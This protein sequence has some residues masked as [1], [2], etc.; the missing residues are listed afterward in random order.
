MFK[1]IRE[2]NDKF[3]AER[4]WGYSLK[5]MQPENYNLENHAHVFNIPIEHE[6]TLNRPFAKG[7][8]AIV[9]TSNAT[10]FRVTKMMCVCRTYINL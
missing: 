3:I 10:G 4:S 1:K 9:D 2:A 6:Y 7:S 5:E 8:V